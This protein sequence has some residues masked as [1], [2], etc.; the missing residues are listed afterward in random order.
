MGLAR[1]WLGA[2]LPDPDTKNKGDWD[3]TPCTSSAETQPAK[4]V[5]G[6]GK[7]PFHDGAQGCA[8]SLFSTDR[9]PITGVAMGKGPSI[10]PAEAMANN[11]FFKISILFKTIPP[12]CDS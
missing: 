9:A 8:N 4:T 6:R 12:A 1:A 10:G 5:Q 7:P 2:G 11:Y 3:G